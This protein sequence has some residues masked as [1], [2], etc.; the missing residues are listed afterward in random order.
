M[1]DRVLARSLDRGGGGETRLFGPERDRCRAR[2]P[3]H[4]APSSWLPEPVAGARATVL[5]VLDGL[6]WDALG[7]L[8]GA[9][10][11]ARGP[12]P[13]GRSPPSCRRPRPPRS[14]RSPPGWR[15]SRHGITGFRIRHDRSVLNAIR[16]QLADGG[17][18]ARPRARAAA[19]RC[20][21]GARSP[22]SPRRCS[23]PPGSPACTCAAATS[24]AGRPPSVA[25]RARAGGRSPTARR[26]CT[27]T[28]RASTRSRTRTAST[29]R[30]T[31]PSS[32]PPTDSSAQ[33]LDALPADVALLV[34]AD[35][36]QVQVG[37]DGW[38]EA[39]A[40]RP[41]GRHLRGRRPVPLPA[42]AAGRRGRPVRGGASSSTATT[43]GCSGAS[44]C[45]TRAGSGPI[46]C[47]PPTGRVG[48]VVLAARTG[49][50]LRR[51]DAALRGAADR[52][53]RIAHRGRDGG[54]PASAARGRDAR[55]NVGEL[56]PCDSSTALWRGLWTGE[57]AGARGK[58]ALAK[59]FVHL[60][61]HTEFSMLDGA[62]RI[63]EVVSKAAADGQPA[64]GITDHGNMYGVLDFYRA[65]READLTPVI[66]T[67]AYMVTTSRLRPAAARPARH[68][69]PHVA[70]G[71]DAGVPQPHQGVVA[72]VPR[73][74]LPEAPRRLRAA[75]AAPRG[76]RR[77]H[78]LP[79]RR[80]V[81]GDCSQDD[82]HAAR[83]STSIASSRSSGATR[84][85]SSCR[86]TACP[87]SCRSTRS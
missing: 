2:A 72:R 47:R 1:L 21:P 35:H 52:R 64:V 43:P 50:G 29:R 80:G 75:R 51:P 18:A 17:R 16:W 30:T 37:P 42:R 3:G 40:A 86:T 82:Y 19:R 33:L 44:S 49:V 13:A 74:L 12:S 60:H 28:T 63:T 32:R 41:D 71:V 54:P 24:T 66:G 20:S 6:G 48:D 87:S 57:I 67:E 46:R 23:A 78:R 76:A 70:R 11:R 26:S 69:P 55:A 5:L 45:S 61:L 56:H 27:R 83:G 36:G 14:R 10:A 31:R 25:G 62:A 34:T 9:P 68:L 4:A 8:P 15:P 53:P 22:S 73:R 77:H 84:S 65:A 59:S 79:R 7:A 58:A 85:S 38:L 81:A 39:R